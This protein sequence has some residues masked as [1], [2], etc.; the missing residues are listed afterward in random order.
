MKIEQLANAQDIFKRIQNIKATLTGL[1]AHVRPKKGQAGD[2]LKAD[3][4]EGKT[5]HQ[6][7]FVFESSGDFHC[8][9]P[10]VLADRFLMEL[11]R[12]FES[13]LAATEREFE[14]L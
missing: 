8:P 12:H 13:E 14:R 6:I 10:K 5:H 7:H 9:A 4:A 1:H 2:T 3:T 11:E